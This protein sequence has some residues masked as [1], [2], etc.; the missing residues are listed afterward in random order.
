MCGIAGTL[1]LGG[2]LRE[3]DQ[4]LVRSMTSVLRHRG[5]DGE[6]VL[7]D[8]RAVLG[9]ARLKITDLRDAANLP[10]ASDDG[11]VWLAYNGAVTN[12]RS[13]RDE[14]DLER[15]RPLRTASDAEVLI[16]LYE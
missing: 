4:S 7:A 8:E 15:K 14:F 10:M 5:P 9:G 3:P 16:R 13:L 12:F 2:P 11:A 1:S 6:R